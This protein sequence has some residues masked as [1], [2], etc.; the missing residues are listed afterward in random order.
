MTLIALHL[1][2]KHDGEDVDL[3][4]G[5]HELLPPAGALLIHVTDHGVCWRV[6]FPYF[7]LIEEGSS[8]YVGAARGRVGDRPSV[9]LFVEPAEGPYEA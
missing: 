2:W 3:G 9:Y 4:V 1:V 7:H 6:L 8:A 5:Y